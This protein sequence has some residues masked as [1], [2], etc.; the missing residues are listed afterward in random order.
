MERW[1]EEEEEEEKV[2]RHRASLSP[3]AL[4]PNPRTQKQFHLFLTYDQLRP[5]QELLCTRWTGDV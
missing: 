3:H 4:L 1:Q 2:Q 5:S